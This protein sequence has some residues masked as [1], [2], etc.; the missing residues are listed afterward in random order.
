VAALLVLVRDLAAGARA[1]ELTHPEMERMDGFIL[2]EL[3]GGR[4]PLP[5]AN[6]EAPVCGAP[7]ARPCGRG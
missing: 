6:V 2:A 4:D 7:G 3:D 5:G 1:G